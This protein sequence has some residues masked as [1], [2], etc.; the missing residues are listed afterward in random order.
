[1]ALELS[2]LRPVLSAPR[3]ARPSESAWLP[4]GRHGFYAAKVIRIAGEE[5]GLLLSQGIILGFNYCSKAE[6]TEFAPGDMANTTVGMLA[7]LVEP[8]MS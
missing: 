2:G 8:C 4:C 6:P 5:C 3:T 7:N 1:M